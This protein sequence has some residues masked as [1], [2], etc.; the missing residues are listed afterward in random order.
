MASWPRLAG[1]L[2]IMKEEILE[3]ALK[4]LKQ[5]MKALQRGQRGA[6]SMNLPLDWNVYLYAFLKLQLKAERR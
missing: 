4:R 6:L 3:G 2:R 1:P 5:K